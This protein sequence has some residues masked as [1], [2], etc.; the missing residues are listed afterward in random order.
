M[1]PFLFIDLITILFTFKSFS[2]DLEITD[3]IIWKLLERVTLTG[4]PVSR[5]NKAS[6]FETFKGILSGRSAKRWGL[7]LSGS[8]M[9]TLPWAEDEMPQAIRNAQKTQVFR[10]FI[11]L[12][13]KSYLLTFSRD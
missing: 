3:P 13:F 5:S 8:F 9:G 4:S 10:I 7:L 12:G 2:E 1:A 6:R 11:G